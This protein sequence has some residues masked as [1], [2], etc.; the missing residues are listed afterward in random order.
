M[1]P[2]SLIF[3]S[4]LFGLLGCQGSLTIGG[5]GD[6]DDSA[7][8]SDDDDATADD[9][10]VAPDDDDIAP[11]DDDIAPDDDDATDPVPLCGT[12]GLDPNE[13][14]GTAYAL[15]PGFYDDLVICQ[16]DADWYELDLSEGD[17][18]FLY[19]GF[20]HGEGDIDVVL[21]RPDG[22]EIFAAESGDDDEYMEFVVPVDGMRYLKVYLWDNDDPGEPGNDYVIEFDIG[23]VDG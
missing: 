10:D 16:D 23:A 22:T 18:V 11:D 9:D 2:R 3:L 1:S 13:T 6:D 7:A 8:G 20:D 4:I 5:F 14:L 21:T 15:N 19:F 12:D 17:N